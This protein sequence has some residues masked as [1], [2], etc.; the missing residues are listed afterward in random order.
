MT[1][2]QLGIHN[3]IFIEFK[4]AL[5]TKKFF[6]IITNLLKVN[7]FNIKIRRYIIY[8]VIRHNKCVKFIITM[9]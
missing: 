8:E 3:N 7:L 6:C 5:I 2:L 4:Y 1:K 9:C